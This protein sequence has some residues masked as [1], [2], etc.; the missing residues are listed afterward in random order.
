MATNYV[1][2][3]TRALTALDQVPWERLQAG[4]Q[5]AID[6]RPQ[7]YAAKWVVC[8]RGTQDAPIVIRGLKSPKGQLPVIDGRNAI[9][10]PVLDFWN[11]NRA[12]IK[13]G[14]ANVPADRVPA[15]I[16][17]QDVEIRSARPAYRFIGR[18]GIQQYRSDAS[19]I[20]IEKGESI[21]I[22]GCRLL[23]SGNGLLVA[24]QCR[25]I[26]IEA[27]YIADNGIVGSFYE[28]NAY[29][30]ALGVTFQGNRFGPLRKGC[31]GNAIKDRS[32]GT[33]IRYNWIEGGNRQLDLVEAEEGKH[34][35]S[36]PYYRQTYVYGNVLIEHD[37]AGNN[38]IVHY[39]GDNGQTHTYRKGTLH[40]YHNTVV[41]YRQ[42]TTTLFRL[43]TDDEM[44]DCRNNIFHVAAAGRI[45]LLDETGILRLDTNWM[46]KGWRP[47]FS[48][49]TAK[50][51][52][53]ETTIEGES[54]GF[55]D[56]KALDFTLKS[57]S[58]CRDSGGLLNARVSF[59]GGKVTHQYLLH[60]GLG[61]RPESGKKDLGAFEFLE[62][63][64]RRAP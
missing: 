31:R 13:I 15:H 42:G 20:Y 27:C 30:E 35:R 41:S 43:S 23:D 52:G 22:R 29:T 48:S 54:P 45:G 14:G 18:R 17:I 61:P 34:L 9:T 38:Q 37:G 55:V 5:V 53:D 8:A 44:V 63:T 28:H 24:P 4:D 36:S 7:P 60:Q 19:A 33:V 40:F 2:G 1:V 16:V 49:P 32:A 11:A 50:V 46:K 51:L 12:V 62:E 59:G 57:T 25:S 3:P 56:A 6:W 64:S 26:L 10:R 39:G 58:P 47:S 21:T